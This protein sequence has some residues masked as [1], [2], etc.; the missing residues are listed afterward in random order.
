MKNMTIENTNKSL[1]TPVARLAAPAVALLLCL[2]ASPA[3]AEHDEDNR[4]NRPPALPAPVCDSVNVPAG[5]R[6]SF[7]AYALGVQ[8]YRWSGTAWVFVGPAA[9]LFADPCYEGQV[10]THYADG[11]DPTHPAWESKDGSKV[12]GARQFGCTPYRGAI[13]WLR[14]GATP[15]TDRGIFSRT[16]Y[17]QRVNTIGGTAPA[18]AGVSMGDEARVPY[19]AEYYFYRAVKH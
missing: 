14:L 13:P 5:N 15:T 11:G 19:T 9:D 8:I 4:D 10:G 2:A 12:V 18:E 6:V 3:W 1:L 17:I 7:H 16:T